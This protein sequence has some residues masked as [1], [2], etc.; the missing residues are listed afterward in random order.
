MQI[1]LRLYRQFDMDLIYLAHYED[2]SMIKVAKGC[3]SAYANNAAFRVAFPCGRLV[4][5]S[6]DKTTYVYTFCLKEDEDA[7]S[8]NFLKE[9]RRH[10]RNSFIKNLIRGYL[11]APFTFPYLRNNAAVALGNDA[12]DCL[13]PSRMIIKPPRKL[14][15]K[16]ILYKSEQTIPEKNDTKKA[17]ITNSNSPKTTGRKKKALDALGDIL[18]P[19]RKED[20]SITMHL[21]PDNSDSGQFPS[22]D[23]S[24]ENESVINNTPDITGS[25]LPPPIIPVGINEGDEGDSDSF[26]LFEAVSEMMTEY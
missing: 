15:K 10:H 13:T 2:F 25:K 11:V 16:D 8:I 19:P 20:A 4:S 5:G 12:F 17:S 3:I 24:S 1:T 22:L 21:K 23:A 6:E 9:V 14:K 7:T 18:I 26:D